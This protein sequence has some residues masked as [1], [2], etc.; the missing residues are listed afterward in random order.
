MKR[1]LLPSALLALTVFA[2]N[3]AEQPKTET[4]AAESFNLA[5]A[6]DSIIAV[7]N[8]STAAIAAGDSV[9]LAA[10]YTSDAKIMPSNMPAV[11][12]TA[13]ITNF[14]S[15]AFKMGIKNIKFEVLGVWGGKDLVGE[16]G[17]FTI[18]D[19]K[20]AVIDKG[21]YLVFWKQEDGKWKLFRDIFNSDMPPAPIRPSD[22][23]R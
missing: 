8:R 4:A 12:G 23:R 19:D 7:N 10:L 2:C 1:L 21:K 11:S 22:R 16:E 18:S 9:A 6:K 5:A 20:G 15:E 17:T 13:G 3:Q 14:A